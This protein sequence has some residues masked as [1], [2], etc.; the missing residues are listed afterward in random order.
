MTI[1]IEGAE[2]APHRPGL[3]SG[4]IRR[5]AAMQA[6]ASRRAELARLDDRT[7]RDIG[8]SRAEVDAAMRRRFRRRAMPASR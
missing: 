7:L 6:Q 8:V 3:I 4:L 2:V 1:A 5:I